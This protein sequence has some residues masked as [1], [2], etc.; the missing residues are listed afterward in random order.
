ML[1]Q[2]PHCGQRPIGLA[3]VLPH[4]WHTYCVIVLAIMM[5]FLKIISGNP[6]SLI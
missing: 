4:C 5:S 1:P 6:G 3:V 2:L